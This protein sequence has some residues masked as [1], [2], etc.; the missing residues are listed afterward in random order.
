MDLY[1]NMATDHSFHCRPNSNFPN[2]CFLLPSSFRLFYFKW[3]SRCFSGNFHSW[4][5]F[6]LLGFNQVP[7]IGDIISIVYSKLLEAFIQIISGIQALPYN[8]VNGVYFSKQSVILLYVMIGMIM[9]YMSTKPKNYKDVLNKKL[10]RKRILKLLLAT[11]I[12]ILVSN[13]ILFS[14]RIR[15]HNELIVYDISKDTA[16]DIFSNKKLYSI[17]SDSIDTKKVE[18]ASKSYRIYN[19]NPEG[20]DLFKTNRN[21]EGNFTQGENGVMIFKEKV[22][23]FADKIDMSKY[24]PCES[25]ILLVVNKTKMLPYKFLQNHIPAL[26]VLDNSLSYKVKNQWIKECKKRNIEI[27]DVRKDGI[28]RI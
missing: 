25:D 22:L 15:N 21:D 26:V 23:V 28:F 24:I 20:I 6:L 18:F 7:V 1:K 2:F 17:Q 19:G 4:L 27:H 9:L 14:Y 16:I 10:T 11:S 8:N 12:V 13:S 3:S 5:G